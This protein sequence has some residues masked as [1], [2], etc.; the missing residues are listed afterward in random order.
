MTAQNLPMPQGRCTPS[1]QQTWIYPWN[2]PW[3]SSSSSATPKGIKKAKSESW[4]SRL[5]CRWQCDLYGQQPEGGGAGRAPTH[6]QTPRSRNVTVSLFSINSHEHSA[7]APVV[8][9]TILLWFPAPVVLGPTST[10]G[11]D[12]TEDATSSQSLFLCHSIVN[13]KKKKIKLFLQAHPH[14]KTEN[15][16][17]ALCTKNHSIQGDI[18]TRW[19]C[20][21]YLIRVTEQNLK[22][23]FVW[24]SAD[25]PPTRKTV[26]KAVLP[27]AW[28][29]KYNFIHWTLPPKTPLQI[30]FSKPFKSS[31]PSPACPSSP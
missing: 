9:E 21:M 18:N 5:T 27:I 8:M 28:W 31:S 17:F 22:I 10:L 6:V 7:L 14:F 16:M 25:A 15:V 29:W 19:Q 4:C 20:M 3:S 23:S 2:E 30:F 13:Y 1:L 11:K 24:N 12:K 26:C